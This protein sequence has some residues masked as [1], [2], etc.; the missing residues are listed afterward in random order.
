[1]KG[2]AQVIIMLSETEKNDQRKCNCPKNTTYPLDGECLES[3]IVYQRATTKKKQ[4]SVL[5][6]QVLKQDSP[7]T[8]LHSN[9]SR[10]ETTRPQQAHLGIEGQ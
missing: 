6:L 3:D 2:L 7:T 4:M 9:Q 8:R 10:N 1:M 5:Q